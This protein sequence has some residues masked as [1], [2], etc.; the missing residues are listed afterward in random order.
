[1]KTRL[2]LLML[3]LIL[4]AGAAVAA[5]DNDLGIK[6]SVDVSVRPVGH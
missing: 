2:L 3:A 4:F 1:M 5:V 6:G